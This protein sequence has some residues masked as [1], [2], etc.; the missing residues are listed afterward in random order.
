MDWISRGQRGFLMEAERLGLT[1]QR[2]EE[3]EETT[4]QYDKIE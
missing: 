3:T 1:S 2:R 4:G